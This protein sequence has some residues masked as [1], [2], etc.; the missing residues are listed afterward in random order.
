MRLVVTEFVSLDGVAENPQWTFPYWSDA[1][2]AFKGEETERSGALLLGRRTY[3]E[4]AKAW[5]QRGDAE[6]GSFF[7]PVKKYVVSST[8]T[9][10]VWQNATFLKGDLRREVQALKAKPGKDLTVHGSLTLARWL[11]NE[12]LVD[13]LRLLVY[14]LVVGQGTKLFD[15]GNAS[16]TFRLVKSQGLEKGV[17]ALVYEPEEKA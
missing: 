13:E 3:E 14:P 11:I 16:A 9:K 12:R 5:P 7:N 6:G 4:F 1:A 17:V 15:A 8:L 2:S 10:D